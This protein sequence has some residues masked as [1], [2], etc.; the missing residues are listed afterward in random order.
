MAVI[1]VT[2]LSKRYGDRVALDGV[3]FEVEAGSIFGIVGPNGAGKTTAVECVAGLRRPDGGSVRVLDLDP[4]R[5]GARLRERV[6]VQL[7]QSRLPDLIRVDE[8]LRLYASFYRRPRDWRELLDQWGLAERRDARFGKLSGGLQQRLLIALALV[9]DPEVAILDELTTGLDPQARRSTW[10]LVRQV[11]ATGVTVLLVSHFMDEVETLCDRVAIFDGGR[12][13]AADTPAGLVAG[14]AI[15]QRLRFRP[16]APLDEASLAGL[17][18]VRAVTRAG[19][20]VVVT[21]TGG[22]ADAVTGALARQRVLVANLRIDEH[23]LDEAYLVLT[24]HP[25]VP[26]QE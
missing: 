5:D 2:G 16:M 22:F 1:E 19:D 25:T 17:P 4:R 13:V 12:I 24:G 8:A 18:G 21:G 6:G 23:S 20:Q 14:A 10:E 26:G 9:G 15:E 7:Q 3:S 11:R